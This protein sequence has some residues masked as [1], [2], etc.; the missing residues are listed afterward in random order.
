MD[1]YT[2]ATKHSKRFQ[3]PWTEALD[4]CKWQS[5]LLQVISRAAMWDNIS[6]T[7]DMNVPTSFISHIQ[8]GAH[9][10]KDNQTQEI[11]TV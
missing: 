11:D 8:V 1:F 5:W 9:P 7:L 2:N 4:Q 6:L 3:L 10:P